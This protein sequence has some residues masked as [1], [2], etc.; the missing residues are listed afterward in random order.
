MKTKCKKSMSLLLILIMFVQLIPANIFASKNQ[1]LGENVFDSAHRPESELDESVSEAVYEDVYG[2]RAENKN[3]M[4]REAVPVQRDVLLIQN[5]SPWNTSSNQQMLNNLGLNFDKITIE[6]A[7]NIEFENYKLIIVAND[8]NN[9]FYRKLST[10]RTKLERY[11]MNGGTLLYGICDAGWGSGY[12]DLLIPGDVRLQPVNYS[13]YNYINEPNHPVVTGELTDRN[14]LRNSDL[15]NNYT[16][17]RCFDASSLPYDSK[18]IFHAGSLSKPTLVEYPIGDGLVIASGLTWEFSWAYR[19]GYD[20]Y[21]TFG[22]KAFDDLIAYAYRVAYTSSVNSNISGSLGEEAIDDGTSCAAGDPVNVVN[23]NYYMQKKD[24]EIG[25]NNPVQLTRFYNS[26]DTWEGSLGAKWHHSYEIKLKAV[27]SR[28]CRITFEDGHTE[29]F[30]H[31]DDGVWYGKPGKYTNIGRLDDGSFKLTEKNGLTYIFNPLGQLTQIENIKG[32]RTIFTYDGDKLIKA[33][34]R[35]GYISFQYQGKLLK[36][37]SDSEGR[38]VEYGYNGNVL[39]SVKNTDG[40]I[41]SYEY[42]DKNRITKTI[43]PLGNIKIQN[44]YDDKGRVTKQIMADGSA[45]FFSYDD[46]A[47]TTNY[48]DRNGAKVSYVRDEDNR[49][50][51]R[52]YVNG[53]EI[54]VF[55]QNNQITAFTDKNGNTYYYEYDAN[56]NITRETNPIGDIT[57]YTYD[58]NN[59]ITSLKN[60]DGSEN[61][62]TYDE[63]GNML[64]AKDPLGR[65][66]EMQYNNQ[67]LPEKIILPNGSVTAFEY[68]GKGNPIEVTD[69][70][71]NITVYS[72]DGLNRV[73]AITKPNGNVIE[74]DYT[75]SGKVKKVTYPDGTNIVALYD[76]RGLLKKETDQEGRTTEYKYNSVGKLS[77]K[78]DSLGGV[79][80][81]EY[82]SMWKLVKITKPD[83]STIS[84]KYNL[85]NE[86]ES[87]TDEEEN[88]KAYEYDNNGNIIKESDPLG[89]STCYSYDALNR[90]TAAVSA[91]GAQ[92]GFEYRYDG[93][94]KKVID[95]LNGASEYK[96]DMAGQLVSFTNQAGD[97][98]KYSYNDIGLV[99]S[100][101]DPNGRVTGYE[102]NNNGKVIKVTKPDRSIER[103]EYDRNGNLTKYVDQNGNAVQYDYDANDR[104]ASIKN[105]L[106]Y[107]KKLEYTASGKVSALIDE[108]GNRTSYGYDSLDRLAEVID[109]KG[110][111]TKYVYDSVGNLI[112]VHQYA[113]VSQE[114]INGM[115]KKAGSSYTAENIELVTKYKYDKRGLLIEETNPASKITVYS[116]DSNG[117]MVSKTDRDGLVT[118]YEY[119]AVNNLSKIGY[120]SGKKVEYEYNL[121]DQITSM[122]DWNGKTSY[123]LDVL[124][125]INKITDYKNRATEY[126]WGKLGEKKSIKYPDGSIVSYDYDSMGRL[127]KVNNAQ[128]KVTAYSYDPAGNLIQKLLPNGIKTENTYDALSRLTAMTDYDAAGKII[129]KYSY[130]YD[131]VGNKTAVERKKYGCGLAVIADETEGKT[132]YKYDSLN[133]LIDIKKPNLTEEKYFYDNLG[134]RV[135]KENWTKPGI[136]VNAVDYKYDSQNRLIE[137]NGKGEIIAGTLVNK[138]VTMEYDERGN[139][140]K[141]VSD[142]RTIG[143]YEFDDTN[144]MIGAKNKFGIL[145][146]FEYDGDG[147]RIKMSVE[148]PKLNIPTAG[149]LNCLDKELKELCGTLFDGINFKKEYNYINDVTSPYNNVLMVE[150]EKDKSQRYTYG[151]DAISVDTLSKK[152]QTM[153]YLQD[154]IGSPVRLTD[155]KGKTKVVYSYDAFGKPLPVTMIS[156]LKCRDNIFGFTGYQHDM[157]TGLMYAQARYYMPEVGRFV[158]EDSYKGLVTD[159]QSLNWYV[160]CANNPLVFV[161][162]SGNAEYAIGGLNMAPEFK[163]DKGFVYNP[164]AIATKADKKSWDDWGVKAW[165]ASFVPWLK[166]ASDMYNHYRSNTGTSMKVDY[167]RA[168]NEDQTIKKY[169]DNEISIMK[170]TVNSIYLNGGN[171]SFEMIG[172][173]QAV[174]NGTS[175]NWQKTVGAH[176]VFGYGKVSINP[177]NGLATMVVTFYMEDM[178][179]FNPGQADIA[180]GTPDAVNGRFAELGWAKEF[181]TYG[182]YTKTIIWKTNNS[183]SASDLNGGGR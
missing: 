111:K 35:C 132:Q 13:Y 23:G 95:A 150:E 98:T 63:K 148:L 14:V 131:P 146:K 20:G 84:Y 44:I 142:G 135:R 57:E 163:H 89:N 49:V 133:Q 91:K 106:G 39:T 119:D 21:G 181:K 86:L 42:D 77:E 121:L 114:T 58:S 137:I 50:Y 80:R 9:Y 159:P 105:V 113:G 83:E 82:D 139:L 117:N 134:N 6:S 149:K 76:E 70:E 53:S 47:L 59:K 166:D 52:T 136:F 115:K 128:G 71:G 16:S 180:S 81:Y 10:I 45:C 145:S 162:P 143:Q 154:E 178:Y 87:V 179:N 100:I 65:E 151:L 12:S 31:G 147:R 7:E 125:R 164:N 55:D 122:T 182:S 123:E 26:M 130:S 64:T 161:D 90:I 1:I 96:Y 140:V 48:T 116:Y 172:G 15:Y 138:P 167:A 40:S 46:E 68:D 108:N 25:G 36:S 75:A 79:T 69:P 3:M 2:N 22:R 74:Y 99:E 62:Y 129:N 176:N 43:D 175:E 72:Y 5:A 88:T 168:Y 67:G 66:L 4:M 112:E 104:L 127:S 54:L 24:M 173:L 177:K 158:S 11:V 8:Q 85:A 34:S 153:Y 157:A 126:T 152:A 33:E 102:Y 171:T 29:D 51:Q 183:C 107:K 92:T 94:I 165:V 169:I 170:N 18:I 103:L 144:K 160:Y 118:K 141:A 156:E 110:G 41:N 73:T 60:P 30:I 97:E 101:T 155:E 19:M 37:L 174:P 32:D 78:T 38:T 61:I 124:G 17:H 120:N 27:S 109:A 28:R 93:K 56:G